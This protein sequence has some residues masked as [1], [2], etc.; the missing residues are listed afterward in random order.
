MKPG[1]AVS[2]LV[3][4]WAACCNHPIE[5]APHPIQVL[6]HEFRVIW[7]DTGVS[8]IRAKTK[9]LPADDTDIQVLY[10]A[11]KDLVTYDGKSNG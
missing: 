7:Q 2:S 9:N 1:A 8:E 6:E 4:S 10:F 5:P 3:T 11:Q